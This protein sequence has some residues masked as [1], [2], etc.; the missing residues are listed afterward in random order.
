MVLD[1]HDLILPLHYTHPPESLTLQTVALWD[2]RNLKAKLHSFEGHT[3]EIFQVCMHEC[4]PVTLQVQWSPQHETVLASSGSDRRL[5]V[6]DLRW[7]SMLSSS[8]AHTSLSPQCF[9]L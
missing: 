8:N 4:Y 7:S 9:V 3:D 6:W 5:H 2:M 1:S